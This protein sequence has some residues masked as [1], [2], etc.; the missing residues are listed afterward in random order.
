MQK[1]LLSTYL[2]LIVVTMIISSLLSW[3]RVN[4]YFYDRI[5]EEAEARITILRDLLEI[6]LKDEAYSLDDFATE[7]SKKLGSRITIID[8]SGLVIAESNYDKAE[9]DDHKTR[10]EVAYALEN[11]EMFSTIRY[12]NTLNTYLEYVVVP[13]H[14]DSV[15]GV[16]RTAKPVDEIKSLINETL[17]MIMVGILISAVIAFIVAYFITR[18]LMKPVNELTRAAGMIAEGDYDNKIYL[19]QKDEIGDLAKAFNVMSYNLRLNMWELETKNSELESILTSMSNGIIVVD[20]DYKITLF[21]QMFLDLFNVEDPDIKGKLFYEATRNLIVFQVLESSYEQRE[22]VVKEA[23]ISSPDGDK[24]FL[25]FASPIINGSNKIRGTLLVVQDVTQ[26]RKLENLRSDF[27][28]NVTHELKT[29][30]TSIRGFV[31][32]LK[33]GAINEEVG[34]KFLDII[35]IEAERLELLINDILILSEIESLMGDKNQGYHDLTVVSDEVVQLL[36]PKTEK[37][38]L[39]IY[40]EY[41]DMLP[42]FECNPN[43]IKQLL[44]NLMDNAVKYTEEGSV[45]LRLRTEYMGYIIEIED[46]GIGIEKVHIPRLF[47]RF[48]RVDRGRSRKMGG[49]GLGLSIVKHIVE[50]YSGS[51]RVKSEPNEGTKITIRLPIKTQNI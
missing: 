25:L 2:I 22:N 24:T 35:D 11:D 30:L 46:T 50:L 49:T 42:M 21:N 29:P 17:Q 32:T 31:D 19:D 23:K 14:F 20:S 18:R 9:M 51:I 44:I 45:T 8:K 3:S 27:V 4:S 41:Q 34:V 16:L 43:R 37:K 13:I 10:E 40:T 12:S 5:T 15:D 28:S 33:S 48:Y 6:S 7:Y 39:Q 1:K 36:T 38:G 26:M 47:E